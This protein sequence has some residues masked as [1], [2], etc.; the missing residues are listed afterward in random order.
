MVEQPSSRLPR[1]ESL[2]P[3]WSGGAEWCQHWPSS[4]SSPGSIQHA[5][6]LATPQHDH[7]TEPGF[8]PRPRLSQLSSQRQCAYGTATP[9]PRSGREGSRATAPPNPHGEVRLRGHHDRPGGR[10]GAVG[11]S[12]GQHSSERGHQG[13]SCPSWAGDRPSREPWPGS[14]MVGARKSQ[15]RYSVTSGFVSAPIRT[16]DQLRSDVASASPA[17]YVV[18]GWLAT[19]SYGVLGAAPKVGKTWLMADLTVSVATGTPFLGVYRLTARG[20]CCRS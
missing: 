3:S 7:A 8:T 19:D 18:R 15:E 2:R 17:Q 11:S 20:R 1:A 12:D 5:L 4:D 6:H 16:L 13:Q 14:C 9:A 10:S